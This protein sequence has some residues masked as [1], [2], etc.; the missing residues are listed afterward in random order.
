MSFKAENQNDYGMVP[1]KSYVDWKGVVLLWIGL[2]SNMA[3]LLMC[4]VL[5]CYE[6]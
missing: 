1:Y 6:G 5:E 4:L 3:T 2:K